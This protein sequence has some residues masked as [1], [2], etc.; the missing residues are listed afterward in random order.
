MADTLCDANNPA[1]A[2][3]TAGDLEVLKKA[4]DVIGEESVRT[5]IRV[6]PVLFISDTL[7][8]S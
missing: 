6:H 3:V 2:P 5:S 4:D 7:A 8:L 1:L